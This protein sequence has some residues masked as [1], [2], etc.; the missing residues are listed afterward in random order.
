MC[1]LN[2]ATHARTEAAA[3]PRFQAQ[4]ARLF[5]PGAQRAQHR[6]RPAGAEGIVDFRQSIGH[7][8]AHAIAAV[9][10]RDDG[11]HAEGAEFFFVKP[12]LRGVEA[13]DGVGRLPCREQAA[14]KAVHRRHADPAAD[15]QRGLAAGG[16]IEAVLQAAQTGAE[17]GAEATRHMLPRFGRSKNFRDQALGYPDAGAVSTALFF[18]VFVGALTI[19]FNW[20]EKKLDYFRC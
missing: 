2:G 11:L 17:T 5:R 10:R 14:G 8:A 20:A 1:C 15:E 4:K 9:R 19:L 12:L 7:K 6:Q 3:H 13:K 18:L 16:D